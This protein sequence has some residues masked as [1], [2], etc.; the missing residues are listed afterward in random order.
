MMDTPPGKRIGYVAAVLVAALV[1]M[2]FM[3]PFGLVVIGPTVLLRSRSR[4]FFSLG[5]KIAVAFGLLGFVAWIVL[6]IYLVSQGGDVG[7]G[8]GLLFFAFLIVW[9]AAVTILFV[10][11]PG[12]TRLVRWLIAGTRK[13]NGITP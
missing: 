13:G 9:C 8:P 1:A 4:T 12:A 10:L 6:V 2:P 3:F 11:I 5:F 7:Q